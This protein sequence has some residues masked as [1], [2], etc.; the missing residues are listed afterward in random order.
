VPCAFI[1]QIGTARLL[2]PLGIGFHMLLVTPNVIAANGGP[3]TV[4]IVFCKLHTKPGIR[5]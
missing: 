3:L 1:L 2:A 5:L 4:H